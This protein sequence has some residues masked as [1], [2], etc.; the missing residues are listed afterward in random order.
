MSIKLDGNQLKAISELKNGNILKGGVGSGKSRTAIGYFFLEV[1]GGSIPINGQGSLGGFHHARD[2]Y[3]ITTAKKRNDL[4]WEEECKDW[5]LSTDRSASFGG[6]KVVVD[7]WN[8]IA[9]YED[10]KDAFFIFDEQRLVGSGA[11]VKAFL[12]IAKKNRWIILSA[13]PGDVW[14]DYCPV[15]IANGFYRNR[16]DFIEQ[17]VVFSRFSK[18]PK[19]D[20]YVEAGRL[21]RL[22]KKIT[23]E[24]PD[25]RH[26]I[27]IV[28]HI[29][30]KHDEKLFEKVSKERWNIFADPQ[31][32]IRDVAELFAT[33]RRLVNSDTSR[34]DHIRKLMEKHPRL[35]IFYNFNYEL[36]A[37]RK[38]KDEFI[39]AWGMNPTVAEYNG[40]KHEPV[41][42]GK[43]WVYLVQYT[44]GAEGWNCITTDTIVFYSLNYSY[45]INEQS[46]GRIDRRNTPFT[47]LYYYIFRSNS[48]IDNAIVK[49]LANKQNFNEKDFYNGLGSSQDYDAA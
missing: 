37:L 35:I 10:V 19:V 27:R 29:P 4:E 47:N 11:W 22:R 41:P 21:L 38:L 1:C 16:T 36:E 23:V 49:S 25:K 14:L 6:V 3:I 33:M 5:R 9:K 2:L 30:V 13:T 12:Q 42:T 31:R 7:S 18:F 28:K 46:K 20:R 48:A 17:H 24:M 26:T 44:A 45:K 32:P 34:I 8:N 40:H 43:H 39:F 15:F